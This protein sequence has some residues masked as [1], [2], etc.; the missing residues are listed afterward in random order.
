MNLQPRNGDQR[1]DGNRC[2]RQ[3]LQQLDNACALMFAASLKLYLSVKRKLA[4]TTSLEN[5][6]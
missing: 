3:Y 2:N 1:P 5:L 4:N 6:S